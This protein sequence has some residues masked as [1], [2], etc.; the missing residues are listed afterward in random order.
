ME[1]FCCPECGKVMEKG[2]LQGGRVLAFTKKR[3][4]LSLLPGENEFLLSNHAVRGFLFPAYLCRDC[5]KILLAYEKEIRP[6][7]QPEWVLGEEE[8]A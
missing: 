2:F 4:R 1:E 7:A 8:K 6:L 3:H 5:K